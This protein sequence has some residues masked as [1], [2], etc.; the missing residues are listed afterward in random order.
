MYK[1]LSFDG[2]GVYGALSLCVINKI[3][4]KHS[5]LVQSADM[6]T[7]TS[8]GSLIAL[9]LA[10]NKS[11]QEIID[12]FYEL[13]SGIFASDSKRTI[14]SSLGLCAKYDNENIRNILVKN[15]GDLRLK[16][17]DYDVVVPA[18]N[19]CKKNH[20]RAPNW[21]AKFF[22]NMGGEGTDDN[23][24]LVDVIIGGVKP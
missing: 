5:N 2:G 18:F 10:A 15:F 3:M 4:Q 19:L 17:L 23:E 22:H 7:G 16:D 20:G 9:T 13:S 1:I 12:Q 6:L 21:K 8:V 24:L 14:C 11:V